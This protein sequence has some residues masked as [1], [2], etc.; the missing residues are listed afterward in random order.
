MNN[1]CICRCTRLRPGLPLT[2]G[3]TRR[4]AGERANLKMLT[5]YI[6]NDAFVFNSNRGPGGT[7]KVGTQLPTQVYT[8]LHYITHTKMLRML[9]LTGTPIGESRQLQRSV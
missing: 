5:V 7:C 1:I 6:N 2:L 8:M 3:L 9:G 4:G